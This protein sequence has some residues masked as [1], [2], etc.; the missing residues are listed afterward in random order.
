MWGMKRMIALL[1]ALTIV[2]VAC[3]RS[4][5]TT[6]TDT[7]TVPTSSTTPTTPPPTAAPDTTLGSTTTTVTPSVIRLEYQVRFRG[8]SNGRNVVILQVEEGTATDIALESLA[9]QAFDEFEPLAELFIVDSE[10]AIELVRLDPGSLTDEEKDILSQHWLLHLQ[11][12]ELTFEGPF[13][14]LPGFIL[15]S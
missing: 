2:G 14:D 3:N 12:A 6:T 11:G 9:R 8:T 13:A 1:M 4:G 15:G 10:E 7:G 5:D